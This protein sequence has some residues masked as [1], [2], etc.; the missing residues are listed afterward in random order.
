[1]LG[2]KAIKEALLA[3]LSAEKPQVRKAGAIALARRGYRSEIPRVFAILEAD[4]QA[5]LHFYRT[6]ESPQK[7]PLPLV[8]FRKGLHSPNA[9]ART[10]V[11][12]AIGLCR[13]KALTSDLQQLIESD[14]D[15]SVRDQAAIALALLGVRDSGDALLRLRDNGYKSP[16]FARALDGTRRGRTSEV[17]SPA[18]LGQRIRS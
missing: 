12:E 6:L 1:L 4:P 8:L 3:A 5:F 16:S 7:G 14:T 10:A 13:A 18:A 17:A 11:V 2:E 15:A 9:A